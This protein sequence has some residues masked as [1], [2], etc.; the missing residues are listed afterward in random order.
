MA[1]EINEVIVIDNDKNVNVGVITATDI[2]AGVISATTYYGDGSNLDGI[3]GLGT[4]LSM[5][6]S[7]ESI[8]Y[9]NNTLSVGSTI[10]VNAPDSATISVGGYRVAYTSY[11][12]LHV[13]DTFDVI[14]SDGDELILD[15]LSLT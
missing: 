5:N 11:A 12:D 4:A 7:L 3:S 2:N 6:G 13:E 10:N 14:V 9:T 1:V 15:V 8:F